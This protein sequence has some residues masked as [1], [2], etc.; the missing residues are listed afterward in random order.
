MVREAIE[1]RASEPFRSED[2]G[3]FVEWQ[4][5]GHQ[6]GATLI[7][8]TEHLE[9]QFRTNRGERHIAQFVDD[10]Q[11]DRV[12]MLLQRAQAADGSFC[13]NLA[14]TAVAFLALSESAPGSPAL[15][16][17][18]TPGAFAERAAAIFGSLLRES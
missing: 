3:P 8:L 12:E 15:D 11:L 9:E 5:A 10:Q 18:S 6:R 16:V 17:T 7:T 2:R 13:R 14:S 4:V 1:Q